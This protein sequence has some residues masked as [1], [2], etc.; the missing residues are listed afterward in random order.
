MYDDLKKIHERPEPFSR[1]TAEKMWADPYIS[2][3]ML[4]YH[5][6]QQTDLASRRFGTID[7]IVNWIDA[8]VGLKGA[9]VL[10][11]GCGPGFYAQ[12]FHDRGA[13]VTGID[14]SPSSVEFAKKAALDNRAMI[15]YRVG[16]YLE[17]P[18][19][20]GLDLV[21][22]I[23]L[24]ICV[25]SPG[26]R[27]GL[28]ERI[29]A[30][31]RPGGCFLFDIATLKAFEEF[32]EHASC[33]RRMMDNFWAQDDYFAFHN[34]FKYERDKL[35]LDQYTIVE[36]DK[37]WQVFN[38]MQYFGEDDIEQLL[39]RCGFSSVQLEDMNTLDTDLKGGCQSLVLAQH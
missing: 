26:Q 1:Y 2:R 34:S 30:A 10:D 6:S 11:L 19:P 12:R 21:V 15:D 7:R 35:M 25:L 31:L 8:Q 5:L 17:A 37:R 16:N 9:R 14:F 33:S 22:L 3:Q 4:A 38:W 27:R 24:D 39:L 36:A 28:L 32:Q 23:Y 29:R 18:L 20:E 13:A